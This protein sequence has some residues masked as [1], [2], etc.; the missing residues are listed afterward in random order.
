MNRIL[1]WPRLV[2]FVPALLLLGSASQADD[3]LDA[4]SAA[5]LAQTQQLL[6]DPAAHAQALDSPQAAQADQ[7]AQAV[8]GSPQNT[9]AIY[10][11]SSDVFGNLARKAQG[12][13]AQL[14]EMLGQALSDP[15]GF[16]NQFTPEQKAK[17]QEI[18]RRIPA[19][20]TSALSQ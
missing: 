6:M 14:N 9:Q 11:L 5:A 7:Q 16:A 19:G 18:S 8:A 17:L 13:P 4:D 1:R 12:D 3:T 10:N 15:A 20:S 2:L